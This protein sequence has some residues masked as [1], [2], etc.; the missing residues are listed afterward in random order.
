MDILQNRFGG[1]H[2]RRKIHLF[3]IIL[4]FFIGIILLG[5]NYAVISSVDEVYFNKISKELNIN[6]LHNASLT[7]IPSDTIRNH[8]FPI[9]ISNEDKFPLYYNC[10]WVSTFVELSNTG[11]DRYWIE[12]DGTN[13]GEGSI[14]FYQE[15]NGEIVQISDSQTIKWSIPEISNKLPIKMDYE[16]F[17]NNFYLVQYEY[18]LIAEIF[19]GYVNINYITANTNGPIENN[20]NEDGLIFPSFDD[21]FNNINL[22]EARRFQNWIYQT[23]FR[24]YDGGASKYTLILW[25]EDNSFTRLDY[26]RKY[27]GDAILTILSH[28][29]I[30]DLERSI[31][32]STIEAMNNSLNV[33]STTEKVIFKFISPHW[34]IA[35]SVIIRILLV[36]KEKRHH[37]T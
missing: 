22:S 28:N 4:P 18:T 34:I 35:G 9:V 26:H 32:D 36:T 3:S 14:Q 27:E 12:L 19:D 11:G 31:Y 30:S 24:A 21:L 8:K 15:Y 2:K 6:E 33:S 13:E 29:I 25:W 23:N 37:F 5:N 16:Y 17:S 10:S 1:I 7:F 20:M